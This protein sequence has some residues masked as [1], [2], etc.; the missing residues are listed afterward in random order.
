M[1]DGEYIAVVV[2]GVVVE[3]SEVWAVRVERSGVGSGASK[4]RSGG[5][6]VP[7]RNLMDLA[8]YPHRVPTVRTVPLRNEKHFKIDRLI[9]HSSWLIFL[10]LV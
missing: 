10:V 3:R 6:R 5:R 9:L 7:A 2:R 8:T 4:G 1:G